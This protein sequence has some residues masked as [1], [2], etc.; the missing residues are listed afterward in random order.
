MSGPARLSYVALVASVNKDGISL[1]GET[2]LLTLAGV[3]ESEWVL[4]LGEL[5]GLK[6]IEAPAAGE[7]GIKELNLGVDEIS[8]GGFGKSQ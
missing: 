2:K 6:L 7:V 5:A 8:S 1:W 4:S 3:N